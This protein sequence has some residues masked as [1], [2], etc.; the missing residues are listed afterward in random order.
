MKA[1]HL[2]ETAHALARRQVTGRPRQSDLKRAISTAYYALFHAL[3][4]MC[5]DIL[6]TQAGRGK[7]A[8]RQVYRALDHRH[9]KNQSMKKAVLTQFPPALQR[10]AKWFVYMQRLRHRADYDPVTGFMRSEVSRH[11]THTEDILKEF[12]SAS[13]NVRREFAI[14][15]LLR[16]RP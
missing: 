6:A 2:L 4:L 14:F 10:F 8:W 5:A 11:V 1:L 15:V 16:L 13:I 12:R 7:P 9:V 3:A